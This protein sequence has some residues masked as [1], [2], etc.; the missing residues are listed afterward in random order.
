MIKHIKYLRYVL[1][2]KWY[3]FLACVE[4][5]IAKGC[6]F[7]MLWRGIKHDWSKFLP[8]EWIPYANYFYGEGSSTRTQS[9]EAKLAFDTA[10]LKHQHRNNHHWQHWI[11]REDSGDTKRVAMP[12]ICIWEMLADWQGAG[13]AIT[14]K[15]GGTAAWYQ[16][17]AERI[18]LNPATEVYVR[19]ELDLDLISR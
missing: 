9:R 1:L 3:V 6:L 14:G 16:K 15:T 8:S 10:W 4:Y 11:L 5:G 18:M 19:T 12:L 13:R 7:R 17:N 2:H